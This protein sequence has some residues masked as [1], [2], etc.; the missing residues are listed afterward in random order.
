MNS[1]PRSSGYVCAAPGFC[2]I[3]GQS[4]EGV[5]VANMVCLCSARNAMHRN[6]AYHRAFA[7]WKSVC[8]GRAVSTAPSVQLAASVVQSLYRPL[9]LPVPFLLPICRS[10]CRHRSFT[11]CCRL[12]APAAYSRKCQPAPAQPNCKTIGRR[13]VFPFWCVVSLRTSS[14]RLPERSQ[15]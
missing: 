14:S 4:P 11:G 15:P 10:L 8:W 1:K 3:E 5:G 6:G 7:K 13:K 12:P 2:C 9:R